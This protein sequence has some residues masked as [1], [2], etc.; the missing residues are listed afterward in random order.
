MP[1][2]PLERRAVSGYLLT[3]L[4]ARARPGSVEASRCWLANRLPTGVTGVAR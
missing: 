3:S 4:T 2:Q 1:V